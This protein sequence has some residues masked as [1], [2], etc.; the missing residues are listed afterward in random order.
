[1]GQIQVTRS[2]VADIWLRWFQDAHQQWMTQANCPEC[3]PPTNERWS[4]TLPQRSGVEEVLLPNMTLQ[5]PKG[6]QTAQ[7]PHPRLADLVSRPALQQVLKNPRMQ[8]DRGGFL[9]C[10]SCYNEM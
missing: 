9:S 2:L 6:H 5:G 10:K 1:M 3:G 7:G 8:C 4:H